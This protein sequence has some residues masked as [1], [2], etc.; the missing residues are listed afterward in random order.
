VVS[1]QLGTGPPLACVDERAAIALLEGMRGWD[2]HPV[3]PICTGNDVYAM[4][5]RGSMEREKHQRWRC[6]SC[7]H[8][9]SVR[10]GTIFEESP[11]PLHLW[12]YTFWIACRQHG[13]T[14]RELEKLAGLS[15][16]SALFVMHR[17]D[18]AMNQSVYGNHATSTV[19][20]SRETAR[21][22]RLGLSRS[23]SYQQGRAP[24]RL[25]IFRFVS[26]SWDQN[27]NEAL[28]VKKPEGGWPL[29]RHWP[30]PE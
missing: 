9:Y 13:I 3:C 11:I 6:R 14:A 27:L 20:V 4:T 12:C 5:K 29:P 26:N 8:Q 18:Y 15:H 1:E 24:V 7:K 19:G 16:K 28:M 2:K 23:G 30:L 17:I 22:M 25:V 10:T 21:R